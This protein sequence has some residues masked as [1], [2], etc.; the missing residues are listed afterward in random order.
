MK[1]GTEYELFVKSI[2]E[3]F[4][5]QDN[6][7]TDVEVHKKIQGKSGAEHEID[8]FWQFEIAG[9]TYKTAIE[10]KHFNSS[11]D[12]GRVQEFVAK[13]QD[14]GDIGGIMATKVGFQ[15]GAI[16]YGLYNDIEM[17]LIKEP[18]P[19]DFSPDTILKI[20]I[21]FIINQSK[22]L[23]RKFNFDG[24]WMRANGFQNGSYSISVRNDIARIFNAETQ[25]NLS[26]LEFENKYITSNKDTK[27][28]QDT[29]SVNIAFNDAYFIDNEGKR[30]KI[31]GVEYEYIDLSHTEELKIDAL[32]TVEA[33]IK[34][35]KDGEIVFM[36]KKS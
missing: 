22:I 27:I 7:T 36:K 30:Y 4:L 33:I 29:Y 11:V 2:Y 3:S 1:A 9:K 31:K 28:A 12:K 8:V 19:T 35:V 17:V 23:K 16:T 18:D 21:Q 25:E 20:N 14:I 15:S 13:L 34:R 26:V 32:K 10:C 5:R 24:E 6:L